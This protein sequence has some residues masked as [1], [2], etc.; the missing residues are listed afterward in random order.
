[1]N[2]NDEYYYLLVGFCKTVSWIYNL[3][4]PERNIIKKHNIPKF[5]W[6]TYKTKDLPTEAKYAHETWIKKN[7]TWKVMLYDDNDIEKYI[8][9][10][11]GD[12]MLFFY[13]NIKVGA[14][15]ADLWRYLILTTHGG[16]YSDIDNVCNRSIN[17]WISDYKLKD[18]KDVL[19]IAIEPNEK[20]LCQWTILSTPN[21]PIM[22][23]VCDYILLNYEKNGINYDD[24]NFVFN[25]TGPA[26]WSNAIK[27]YLE[28]DELSVKELYLYYYDNKKIIESKGLYIMPYYTYSIIYVT[29]LIGSAMFS[30]NYESW[31]V[32]QN[33]L[34]NKSK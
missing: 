16:V 28:L 14:M 4:I 29:T 27:N 24:P 25:T 34:I 19:L 7:P 22:K 26:I 2:D 31:R 8:I 17:T 33:K 18:K 32:E 5:I 20:I 3:F 15:K 30:N 12:R 23:H 11:W 6:Q 13:K 10:Y 9:E 1:M 21:H